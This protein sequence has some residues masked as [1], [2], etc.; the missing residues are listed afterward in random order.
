MEARIYTVPVQ[1]GT[2]VEWVK[3]PAKDMT[4]SELITMFSSLLI[5]F[6]TEFDGDPCKMRDILKE[7]ENELLSRCR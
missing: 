7:L 3:K 1:N 6:H 5:E 2:R 4:P